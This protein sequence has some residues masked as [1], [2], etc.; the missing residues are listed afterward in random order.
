[1]KKLPTKTDKNLISFQHYPLALA[2]KQFKNS[3]RKKYEVITINWTYANN[4]PN[5]ID[6]DKNKPSP[7][8][9]E[10]HKNVYIM[11]LSRLIEFIRN[12]HDVAEDIISIKAVDT[13]G[14]K[15]NTTNND[16]Q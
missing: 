10:V 15:A 13:K 5:D 7:N 9:E 1:M 12:T 16:K 4:N 8:R 3:G 11:S 6:Y 2:N 14:K